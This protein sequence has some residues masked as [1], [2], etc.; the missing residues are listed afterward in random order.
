MADILIRNID[1]SVLE[2]L[3]KKAKAE[4]RS[5]NAEIKAILMEHTAGISRDEAISM[6]SDARER[7]EAEAGKMPDLEKLIREDRDR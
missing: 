1:E 4:G 3:K 5:M 6:I 2:R 7:Y